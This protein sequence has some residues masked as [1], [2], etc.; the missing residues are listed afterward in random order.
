MKIVHNL[1]FCKALH[2]TAR[3]RIAC[4]DVG[5]KFIGVAI[6]DDSRTFAHP[7][8]AI[9]RSYRG[10]NN[11]SALEILQKLNALVV[12]KYEHTTIA[13][14][15]VGLPLLNSEMTPFC[16]EIHATFKKMHYVHR[17]LESPEGL[18]LN[19]DSEPLRLKLTSL[20]PICT[21]WNEYNSTVDAKSIIKQVSNKQSV[22]LT[23]KDSIAASII[24]GSFLDHPFV[25]KHGVLRKATGVSTDKD[26]R[27]S[28]SDS[29]IPITPQGQSTSG[30]KK[31]KKV[32]SRRPHI[33]Y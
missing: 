26:D 32:L 8:G 16:H 7:I 22:K 29:P 2:A 5:A 23:A 33:I 14:L 6:S 30:R 12:S 20:P 1:E 4:V 13:G 3:G 27:G 24:L 10:A 15:V 25:I 21:Y 28:S 18:L 31:Q 9:A 11:Q 19:K 17:K